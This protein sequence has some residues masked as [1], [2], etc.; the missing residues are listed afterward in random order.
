MEPLPTTAKSL[1]FLSH[2]PFYRT[3]NMSKRNIWMSLTIVRE[4]DGKGMREEGE[5]AQVKDT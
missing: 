4:T 2:A 1:V 3:A 5:R